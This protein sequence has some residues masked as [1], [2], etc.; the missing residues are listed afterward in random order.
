MVEMLAVYGVPVVPPGNS[1]VVIARG[2]ATWMVNDWVAVC[3]GT[4]ESVTVTVKVE[5][6]AVVG[7]PVKVPVVANVI[8]AGNVPLVTAKV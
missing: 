3:G 5:L 6:P 1:F 8:P 7:V 4:E 2:F